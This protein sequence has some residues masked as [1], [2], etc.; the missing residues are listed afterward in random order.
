MLRDWQQ[1]R[2]VRPATKLLALASMAGLGS[3]TLLNDN[4]P[5]I[6]KAILA[7]LM[8]VGAVVVLRLRTVKVAIQE[9][10]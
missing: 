6:A 5:W 1:H 9:V 10:A 7:M 8:V 2:G 3:I 4:I